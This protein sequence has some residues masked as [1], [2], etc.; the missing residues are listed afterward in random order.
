MIKIFSNLD[1][2][3]V[4]KVW[5]SRFHILWQKWYLDRTVLICYGRMHTIMSIINLHILH[6]CSLYAHLS[7]TWR[8]AQ[9]VSDTREWSSPIEKRRKR[10]R[11]IKIS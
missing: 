10:K 1:K 6:L 9:L 5:I 4:R 11:G 8:P 2:H 3:I 7:H